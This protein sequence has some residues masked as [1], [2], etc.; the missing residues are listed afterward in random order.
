MEVLE[1]DKIPKQNR[2][3][4]MGSLEEEGREENL[5]SKNKNAVGKAGQRIR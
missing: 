1:F 4:E 5:S 2:R 3:V